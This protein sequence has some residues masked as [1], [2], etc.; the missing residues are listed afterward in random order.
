MNAG[1]RAAQR[2][3]DDQVT[4]TPG[5]A[6]AVSTLPV[7][8][9][10]ALAS[11]IHADPFS[12]LGPHQI[13]VEGRVGIVVRVFLPAAGRIDLV[14]PS[15]AVPMARCDPAGLFEAFVESPGAGANSLNTSWQKES[16]SLRH[17]ARGLA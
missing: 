4:D 10:E 12:V 3:L 2:G 14:R 7:D 17:W 8:V 13:T 16:P 9:I 1:A 5:M 6:H 11:A 15:G